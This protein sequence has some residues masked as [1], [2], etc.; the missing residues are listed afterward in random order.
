MFRVATKLNRTVSN[1]SCASLRSAAFSS[2]CTKRSESG[3]VEPEFLE[4]VSIYAENAHVL[5]LDN[6]LNAP[7]KPGERPLD[8]ARRQLIEGKCNCSFVQSRA[9]EM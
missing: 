3:D 1:I 4:M 6:F 7:L 9:K 5:A 2:S 8:E